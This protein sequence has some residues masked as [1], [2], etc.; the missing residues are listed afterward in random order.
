MREKTNI[1]DILNKDDF[2]SFFIPNC[3]YCSKTGSEPCFICQYLG[4]NDY[5]KN[6]D[7]HYIFQELS[8][9]I[10]KTLKTAQIRINSYKSI[11]SQ[12]RKEVKSKKD[13]LTL[14]Y[15][16]DC[17]IKPCFYC[18]HNSVGLDRIDNKKGHSISNTVQCCRECNII[19]MDKFS[20]EE[21][22]IIGES[23]KKIKDARN[24]TYT[25]NLE[26]EQLETLKLLNKGIIDI[27]DFICPIYHN[28]I[29]DENLFF[30]K[31]N[32]FEDFKKLSTRL[33]ND[34]KFIKKLI[35]KDYNM[36]YH[37]PEKYKNNIEL[38]IFCSNI[39]HN[40]YKFF[41]DEVKNNIEVCKKFILK[42]EC[43]LKN[44]PD[45]IKNDSDFVI[46]VIK[47]YYKAYAYISDDLKKNNE[48]KQLLIKN[49][50]EFILKR[51]W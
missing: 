47:Q 26:L 7:L 14:K 43:Y 15:V 11:D 22:K 5:T 10:F 31:N 48:F 3:K 28:T 23:I 19:R 9:L 4:I 25:Y 39:N 12:K 33:I 49:N 36:I 44:A 2:K 8:I 17:L 50:L 35:F 41:S 24:E 16:V 32:Y 34:I 46:K 27:N 1:C 45:E 18:G 30:E 38:A 29:D 20:H 42:R 37:L 21:F 40:T 6:L 13:Q 51:C